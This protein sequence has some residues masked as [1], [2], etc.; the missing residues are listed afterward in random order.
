[1]RLL[2]QDALNEA[3]SHI[4]MLVL[5]VDG[6]LTDG[7]IVYTSKGEQIQAFH[8]HDGFG[9]KLLMKSD[10]KVVLLSARGGR[11]LEKRAKELGIRD[12]YQDRSDKLMIYEQIK[13]R[14][15][16]EDK[17]VAFMGDDWMDLPIL[18][19][20]GLSATVPDCVEA[21]KERVHYITSREGGRGAVR[22]VCEL[23]LRSKDLLGSFLDQFL[24]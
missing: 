13:H 11:A 3:A 6:I 4:K 24:A 15:G 22:E 1:M 20:V 10:I 21:V 14:F 17:Q 12:L 8:V 9:L 7:R 5:D 18:T 2:D 16:L 19:R 23:I